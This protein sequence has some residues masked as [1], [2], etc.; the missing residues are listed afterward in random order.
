MEARGDGLVR[1]WLDD[2][3]NPADYGKGDWYW[4]LTAAE[5]IQ[6]F[7]RGDITQ[8][9]LDHDLTDAQMII[10]GYNA[11]IHED[12]VMSGYDVLLW[13]EQNPEFYPEDGIAVHS[14][15]P[16]G[17]MRMQQAIKR[18]YGHTFMF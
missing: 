18:H 11:R 1:L 14:Q 17:R 7:L 9:S 3:R 5:A 8:A 10:G 15:N 6:A 16:A 4:A 12:G 13:L 2:K